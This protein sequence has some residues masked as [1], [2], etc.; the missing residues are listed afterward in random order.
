[1]DETLTCGPGTTVTYQ[2]KLCN[3]ATVYSYRAAEA[4]TG[5]GGGTCCGWF[6]VSGDSSVC[7]TVC[8]DVCWSV[9]ALL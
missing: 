4:V 1:V 5:A 2:V 3:S 7:V 6:S 9:F 8:A